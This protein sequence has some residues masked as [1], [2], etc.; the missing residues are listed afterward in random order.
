LCPQGLALAAL[1]VANHRVGSVQ[2]V[3][4]GAVI[5]L[6]ADGPCVLIALLEAENV[7]YVRTPEAVN[8]LVVI[9]H[10]ANVAVRACQQARQ[11][12]L[13][14]VGILVLVN[15]YITELILIVCPHF[16]VALQQGHRMQD[17]V[18]KV[19]GVGLPE[20][21][22]VKLIYFTNPGFSPISP[23]LPQLAKLLRGEH[24]PLGGGNH[25]QQL[26]SGKLLFLQPQ[27][28]EDV[29]DDPLGV[30]GII[31]GKVAIVAQ[32]INIPT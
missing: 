20:L 1:V 4:G 5:L 23:L 25:R 7:G 18:V 16:L 31:D 19:Q 22:V 12:K 3:L 24:L 9:A 2:N 14:V 30:V 17:D 32:L 11:E 13:Q 8:A 10:H 29:L 28:L 21:L 26:P 6:Q 27:V 15:E